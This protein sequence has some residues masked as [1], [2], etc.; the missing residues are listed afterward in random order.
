MICA[1]MPEDSYIRKYSLDRIALLLLFVAG[2]LIA[3]VVIAFRSRIELSEPIT[4]E[5]SGLSL[6]VPAGE[7]WV[8]PGPW[9]YEDAGFILQTVFAPTG[10]RAM[11]S[12][13]CRYLL[14]APKGGVNEWLRQQAEKLQGRIDH[15]GQITAGQVVIDWAHITM[16]GKA[17]SVFFGVAVLPGRRGLTIEAYQGLLDEPLGR[18]AFE[19]VSESISFTDNGLLLKGVEIVEKFRKAVA[20]GTEKKQVEEKFFLIL[21][22]GK[23]LR[24]FSADVA[25]IVNYNGKDKI[26]A[27]SFYYLGGPYNVQEF[28][29]G[30]NRFERFSWSV[31]NKGVKIEL[32]KEQILTVSKAGSASPEKYPAGPAAVPAIL[33]D[34]LMRE[35]LDSY[36][37]TIIVDMIL[38]DGQ[39]VPA[40]ISKM[41]LKDKPDQQGKGIEAL[42]LDLLGGMK[43]YE[44]VYFDRDKNI[45]RQL[46]YNNELLIMQPAPRDAVLQQ[47]LKWQKPVLQIEQW[48]E[49]YSD[50]HS[51]GLMEKEY[52]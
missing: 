28:F 22:A 11:V 52:D 40:L 35:F 7:A 23:R 47:F 29:V 38:Y 42:R 50:E 43:F 19:L 49:Q 17:S 2:L 14:A 18:Q 48:V 24:G 20:G 4:L 39:I 30:D 31:P 41:E 1:D 51:E 26:I 3:S 44:E 16:P 37:R 46:V 32:S 36:E 13:Q 33:V 34:D 25:A 8:S 10:S 15:S 9:R 6:R 21:D 27:A 5:H 45:V 12:I